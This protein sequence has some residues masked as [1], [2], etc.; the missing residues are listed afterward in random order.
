MGQD[1]PERMLEML[2]WMFSFP[3][4]P[5][6]SGAALALVVSLSYIHVTMETDVGVREYS[7]GAMGAMGLFW[8]L[9]YLS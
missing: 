6:L 1:E 9:L 8:P 4:T 3:L 7:D 5:L 2:N